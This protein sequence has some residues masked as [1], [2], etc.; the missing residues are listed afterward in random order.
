VTLEDVPAHAYSVEWINPADGAL[1]SRKTIEHP[2]G[3][4]ALPT[5][6][7]TMDLALR[8]KAGATRKTP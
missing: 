4:L 3:N 6:T 5:P 8:M 1:V 7:Y 2:G